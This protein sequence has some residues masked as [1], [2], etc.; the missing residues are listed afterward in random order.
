MKKVLFLVLGLGLLAVACSDPEVAV[1][2]SWT[3][4]DLLQNVTVGNT[5]VGD[6]ANGDQ[7]A[8]V[9]A[10]QTGTV[11]VNCDGYVTTIFTTTVTNTGSAWGSDT[12]INQVG[13]DSHGKTLVTISD[14]GYV[15][16]STP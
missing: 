2:N 9:V 15:D 10:S 16:G 5:A 4:Y 7:S 1:L 14:L 12:F 8:W 6:V 11:Y 3:G 13:V